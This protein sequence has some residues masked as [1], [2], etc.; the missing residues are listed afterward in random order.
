[1]TSFD[2]HPRAIA[3]LWLAAALAPAAGLAQTPGTTGIDAEVRSSLEA[4]ADPARGKAAFED[5]VVCHRKDASG[6]ANG[7]VPR[8]AGQHAS[9]I[10]KQ[11]IDVRSGRRVNERMK[12]VIDAAPLNTQSIADIAGYLEQLPRA[13]SA[14]ESRGKDSARGKA[15]Y[16]RDCARCHGAAGEGLAAKF[17][18]MVATQHQ[19]YL[20]REL[21]LIR[22]EGRGN[23]DPEM[24]RV[25]KPYSPDDLKAVADYMAQLPPPRR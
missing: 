8:L 23:S 6:R 9:V 12:T 4:R 7:S 25:I 22:D 24:V 15:L 16:E 20:L 13:T 17:Y 21:N 19:A 5:C 10:I 14:G 18:P 2:A 3:A 11:I 1:M